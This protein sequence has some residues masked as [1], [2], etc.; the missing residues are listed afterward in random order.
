MAIDGIPNPSH[1]QRSRYV[2]RRNDASGAAGR[3]RP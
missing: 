1:L 2:E 3:R